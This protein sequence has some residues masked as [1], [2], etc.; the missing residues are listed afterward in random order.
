MRVKN[1]ITFAGKSDDR[2]SNYFTNMVNLQL[3]NNWTK[4]QLT[5]HTIVSLR[6]EAESYFR[7]EL[8]H[9]TVKTVDKY[10]FTKASSCF[11]SKV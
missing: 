4:D 8:E 6:G 7:N 3:A 10:D 1:T 5:G 11:E 9:E 2:V